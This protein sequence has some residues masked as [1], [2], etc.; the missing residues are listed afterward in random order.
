MTNDEQMK[1]EAVI[2]IQSCIRGYLHRRYSLKK[3]LTDETAAIIIQKSY[4]GFRFRKSFYLY[5]QRLSTQML[6]FLQ[7]IDL[8]NNDF[9][10]KIVRTNYCVSSKSIEST[11][12][13][14]I[15][16]KFTQHL[17]PPPPLLS[18]LSTPIKNP[19]IS[20]PARHHSMLIS[21]SNR[22]PSPTSSVSKFA[23][24][25]DIFA[26]AEAT[27]SVPTHH[28]I[29]VKINNH[30]SSNPPSS[31]TTPTIEQKS[32]TVL[33]AVQEYQ[34]Q[35]INIHQPAFKRFVSAVTNPNRSP[36]I[37]GLRPRGIGQLVLNNHKLQN[38]QN[39]PAYATSSPKTIT[40]VIKWI[41]DFTPKTDF[42][43]R[44]YQ[45]L[46]NQ[47]MHFMFYFV[48]QVKI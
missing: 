47:N 14:H 39:V 29:P 17:F 30:I 8:I 25:R 42:Y 37:A 36:N 9:F 32:L 15:E 7:Q 4:R 11:I 12:N 6:C 21:R 45:C 5:K 43:S 16:T 10:T 24:V 40:Q 20:S 31:F 19:M 26:R 44:N 18:E 2:C 3:P 41:P 23:Q 46:L 34:R 1:E 28:P 48:K 27:T 33:N 13:H 35:H 38:K 22:S